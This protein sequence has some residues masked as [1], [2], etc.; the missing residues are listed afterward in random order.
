MQKLERVLFYYNKQQTKAIMKKL[1]SILTL[2]LCVCSGAWGDNTLFDVDFSALDLDADVSISTTSSSAVFIEKTY[3]GYDMSFGVKSGKSITI[4]K[5]KYL[6]FGGNNFNTYQQ[7]AI[8]L[9]LV[10]NKKV[11]VTITLDKAG[12][13]RYKW[14]EG[15]LPATPTVSSGYTDYGTSASINTLEY[16][17][18]SSGNYVFYL[19]RKGSGD[20]SQYVKSIVITQEAASEA[21]TVT[22]NAGTN[23]TCATTSLTE[24]SAG[25]GVILPAVTPNEGYAFNG[26]FTA[27]SAGTKAGNAGAKYYPTSDITLHAQ[28]AVYA[29]PTISVEASATSVS[30]GASATLTATVTGTPDPTINWYACDALGTV[31]GESLG[32]ATTYSPSTDTEGTFYYKATATNNYNDAD[33][34]ATSDVITFTVTDPNKYATNNAYYMSVGETP[35]PDEQIIGDDITMT[36]VNGK[37]GESFTA[38]VTDLSVNGVNKNFVASISG[39]PDNNGWKARFVPTTDGVLSVGVV[40]NKNKTFSISNA[41]EFRYQGKNG[42]N[43]D[44][45]ETNNSSSLTTADN[46]NAK[47]YVVVTIAVENGKTYDFSVAGSKM[48]FY[49]FE[50]H[51]VE[52]KN[53]NAAGYSTFS[54][55]YDVEVSGAKAYTAKLDLSTNTITCTEIA[56]SK[57]PA[58]AGV[59]IFKEANAEVTFT[60]TYGVAALA[61]NDLKGSTKADGSLATE[62]TGHTYYVLNGDTFKE[63]TA[64]TFVAGKAYFDVEGGAVQGKLT[65]IFDDDETTRINN[66]EE[67]GA[68]SK[69]QEGTYNLAGQKVSKSYKG[70]VIVNGKKIINK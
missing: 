9:T 5:G 29:A 3:N 32:T 34:V 33:H 19:G 69:E 23:G 24:A 61:N 40:I 56:D 55:N 28:Y 12:Q 51:K 53:L 16:T 4:V 26:W 70:I 50:F 42:A 52:T 25:A 36:F 8:P 38:G 45:D 31:S 44:V 62:E 13:A 11:T 27:A 60:P 64:T 1:L 39:S 47:L 20:G 65:I 14:V 7:L 67:Q 66:I 49:G 21:Y 68:M 17:P 41:T 57:V 30:K 2:L 18:T 54:S 43:E 35:V 48:G 63:Y 10:A 6:N 59:L 37:A 58:G 46:D 15:A 22:F